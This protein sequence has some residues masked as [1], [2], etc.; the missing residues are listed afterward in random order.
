MNESRLRSNQLPIKIGVGMH[1]GPLIMGITGDLERLDATTIADTVNTASRLEGL[2]KYFKVDILL[3]E[4][5]MRN[6]ELPD[7][8][9]LRHLGPVQL[10][11]KMEAIGVYECFNAGSAEELD[12][13]LIALPVFRQGVSAYFNKSFDDASHH[14]AE[15]LDIYP[16]DTTAKMFLERS[17]QYVSRGVPDNWTGVEAMVSK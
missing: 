14:F 6:W 9:H 10:K 8:F 16:E 1:T 4:A 3:R 12:K 11:G 5:S 17:H 13:K 7:A 15:V 2:T